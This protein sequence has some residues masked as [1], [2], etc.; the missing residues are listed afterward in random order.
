MIG[1][2][3]SSFSSGAPL[4]LVLLLYAKAWFLLRSKGKTHWILVGSP[5]RHASSTLKKKQLLEHP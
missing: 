5:S 4:F 3:H 2:L 1:A